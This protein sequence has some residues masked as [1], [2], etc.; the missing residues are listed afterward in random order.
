MN[1]AVC[2]AFQLL[3]QGDRLGAGLPGVGILAWAS[4]LAR[5]ESGPTGS[6]HRGKNQAVVGELAALGELHRALAGV[7]A[8]GF[9]LDD[10]DTPPVPEGCRGNGDVGQVLTPPMTRLEMGQETN[11]A[12]R[13]TRVTWMPPRPQAQVFGGGGA[14]EAAADHDH[15]AAGPGAAGAAVEG[16]ERRRGGAGLEEIASF[17]QHHGR[18]PLISV[19]RSSRRSGRAVRRCSPGNLVHDRCR[20]DAAL[21]VGEFCRIL[22]LSR[23]ARVE[24]GASTALPLVP[25]QLAQVAARLRA[26]LG[27]AAWAVPATAASQQGGKG[28]R[29]H[30]CLLRG[31]RRRAAG[32]GADRSL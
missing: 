3:A 30:G 27:S 19:P 16:G 14:A 31:H 2:H 4:A 29:F 20:F 8:G 12:W 24:A 5:P 28:Q 25:W 11:S 22:A 7:D 10:T 1:A 9:V 32:L 15:M 13:S 26:R 17:H 18:L 6:R 21:E 23:P